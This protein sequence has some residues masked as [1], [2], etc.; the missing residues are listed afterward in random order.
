MAQGVS[1]KGFTNPI[2]LQ[3]VLY[4]RKS[5]EYFKFKISQS[6]TESGLLFHLTKSE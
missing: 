5:K 3:K 6:E 2:I 4:I 1:L